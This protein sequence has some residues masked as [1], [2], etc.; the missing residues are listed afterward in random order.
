LNIFMGI[1]G[2]KNYEEAV[3]IVVDIYY[4]RVRDEIYAE[5]D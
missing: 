2:I 3:R 4:K 5:K 1:G